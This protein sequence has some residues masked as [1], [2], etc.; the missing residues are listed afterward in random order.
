MSDILQIYSQAKQTLAF[1]PRI[2]N[3][4][5]RVHCT[6]INTSSKPSTKFG[7]L[8]PPTADTISMSATGSHNFVDNI[9]ENMKESSKKSDK[10]SDLIPIDNEQNNTNYNAMDLFTSS[11]D[12]ILTT[13]STPMASHSH[14]PLEFQPSTDLEDITS[15]SPVEL[16][17][18]L[19]KYFDYDIND[20]NHAY[21][22]SCSPT[23]IDTTA[24][25]NIDKLNDHVNIFSTTKPNIKSDLKNNDEDNDIEMG[26]NDDDDKFDEQLVFNP[27]F[28]MNIPVD[29]D[30]NN[31]QNNEMEQS[32]SP[33]KT[34]GLSPLNSDSSLSSNYINSRNSPNTDYNLNISSKEHSTT[35]FS[36]FNGNS[37]F[38]R[39]N[40]SLK[41][42]RSLT[43]IAK[44]DAQSLSKSLIRE[45]N[46][47]RGIININNNA[48]N[49]QKGR[50][51]SVIGITATTMSEMSSSPTSS[52]AKKEQP[53]TSSINSKP[54]ECTNC[55][56]KTTPLWR[57]DPQGSPLCNACGL[58]Q[59]LHGVSRP[60]S[61]KTDI[62]KKRNTR[63]SSAQNISNSIY[64]GTNFTYN[65]DDNNNNS[66]NYNYNGSGQ[67]VSLLT[68]SLNN[69][70]NSNQSLH[71][72]GQ[73]TPQQYAQG[74]PI[75]MGHMNENNV[76]PH[77]PQISMNINQMNHNFYQR[78]QATT[79][80]AITSSSVPQRVK[81]PVPI[82][83]KSFNNGT[84]SSLNSSTSPI[85][86]PSSLHQRSRSDISTPSQALDEAMNNCD[87]ESPTSLPSYSYS[88][89]PSSNHGSND[90]TN[91]NSNINKNSTSPYYFQHNRSQLS[92]H[93]SNFDNHFHS[94]IT[95]EN[96]NTNQDINSPHS[97]PNLSL[98][99]NNLNQSFM[100]T[101]S[102]FHMIE[103]D[104]LGTYS[105][106]NENSS[107]NN[108]PNSSGN[109]NEKDDVRQD[110]KLNQ[111]KSGSDDNDNSV[112]GSEKKIDISQWDWLRM[113]L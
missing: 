27:N 66:Y 45:T 71:S 69:A 28:K 18:Y 23:T 90:I 113:G 29:H 88:S 55:H 93:H 68:L 17:N 96:R 38:K 53:S 39:R 85:S 52:S 106:P 59:K 67:K 83:P 70:S 111:N 77:P 73:F 81:A 1:Q 6:N 34:S 79:I 41:P 7:L 110:Q 78:Q 47:K 20:I 37:K 33:S 46:I 54:T 11:D 112:E 98:N 108:S 107:D 25:C 51:S 2:E 62:I 50:S 95:N 61:L 14:S 49:H 22:D 74:Y 42:S 40:S 3:R 97:L 84:S 82:L 76:Y 10:K 105:D 48:F 57:R 16:P 4:T 32:S 43:A 8:S 31:H 9:K 35:N 109:S 44:N 89:Y 19:A 26:N 75:P 91:I 65:N 56:T 92:N 30:I 80:S 36:S 64:F 58:F 104:N 87:F 12:Q 103:E 100:F 94:T 63:K 101:A 72:S 24:N 102:E 5:W 21:G 99:L 60:L 15:A 13:I 86:M